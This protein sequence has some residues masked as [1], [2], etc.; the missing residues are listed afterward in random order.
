[1]TICL[2]L[3]LPSEEFRLLS[4]CPE[5]ESFFKHTRYQ[6]MCKESMS[7][8]GPLQFLNDQVLME[9][10]QSVAVSAKGRFG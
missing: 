8:R 1:M 2:N 3:T 5:R 9:L 4:H 10:F 6:T 7:Q